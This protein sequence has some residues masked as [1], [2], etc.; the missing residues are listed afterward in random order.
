MILLCTTK[1]QNKYKNTCIGNTESCA[2]DNIDISNDA[3]NNDS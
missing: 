2:S 1:K 3:S